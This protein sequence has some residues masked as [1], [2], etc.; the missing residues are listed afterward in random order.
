M[1]RTVAIVLTLTVLLTGLPARAEDH[2]V[3]RADMLARL[4]EATAKREDDLA[5]VSSCL[6]SP[7]GVAVAKELGLDPCVLSGRV[8]ALSDEELRDLA[9]RVALLDVDPVAGGTR[10][11]LIILALVVAVLILTFVA[12]EGVLEEPL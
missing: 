2:V 11:T 3:S 4:Y 9:Q 8:A 10:K 1:N 12:L 6:V 7:A 5:T